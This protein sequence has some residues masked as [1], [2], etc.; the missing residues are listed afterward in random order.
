MAST[1]IIKAPTGPESL[2]DIRL[3]PE[4]H[5]RICRMPTEEAVEGL[6]KIYCMAVMYRGQ[7]IDPAK[8]DFTA[9]TLLSE[10]LEDDAFGTRNVTLE[11]IRRAVKKAVLTDT[12]VYGINVASLFR[13]VMNYI[14]GEGHQADE[15]AREIYKRQQRQIGTATDT[16][17]AV[18]AGKMAAHSKT[19]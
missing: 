1:E 7:D 16:M 13:I 5:P 17:L 11:E 14:K 3:H 2:V 8:A 15:Q 19:R 9:R 4:R 18:Y 6:K 10:L 12:E